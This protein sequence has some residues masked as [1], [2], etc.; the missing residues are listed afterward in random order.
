[1]NKCTSQQ[2]PDR[3][4]SIHPKALLL[5]N[6][7]S[8]YGKKCLPEVIWCLENTGF[9]LVLEYPESP[10]IVCELIRK[11]KDE[12]D[13]V[14][15]AGGDTALSAAV[16]ALVETQ[17]PLGIIPLGKNNYLA[18]SLGIPRNLHQACQ[19]IATGN[20]EH[21]DL[22]WVN[23]KYFIN[24]ASLGLSIDI[25]SKL[26]RKNK[27]PWG[28]FIY[29]GR[30]LQ[31]FYESSPF[32]TKIHHQN[33]SIPLKTVHIGIYN[34]YYSNKGINV[35]EKHTN[36]HNNEGLNIHSLKIE[37]RWQIISLLQALKNQNHQNSYINVIQCGENIKIFT[38]KPIP[39]NTDGEITTY[40]PAEF[41]LVPQVL[42]VLIPKS[43]HQ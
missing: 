18:K 15:I 7:H 4:Q 21:I 17:L 35:A 34:K 1:M 42:P 10:Q 36:F 37:H 2:S 29:F 5:I 19:F 31:V 24:F 3:L 9:K 25:T 22:G 8:R 43:Q 13:L 33:E 23:G 27:L 39:V 28:L 20:I 12:V 41:R 26:I 11:Y 6:F 30:I 32:S 14:I 16:N 40:T 38:P